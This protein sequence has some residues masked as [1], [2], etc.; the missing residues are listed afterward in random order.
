MICS[1]NESVIKNRKFIIWRKNEEIEWKSI[2]FYY[3][4]QNEM[5]EVNQHIL[6]LCATAL[7]QNA[8][9]PMFLWPLATEH[10]AHLKN[11]SSQWRFRWKTLIK[12]LTDKRS[13]LSYLQIWNFK[14]IYY[15]LK[16]KHVK[17]EKYKTHEKIDYLV[18]YE[19][20]II[21]TVKIWLSDFK[22]IIIE[23][24]IEIIELK[25]D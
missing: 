13:D 9:L 14:V 5:S 1:N 19:N 17:S 18:E 6:H 4:E 10:V 15:I 12:M 20:H 25:S 2:V 16:Q 7:L 11:W 3:S 24:N 23:Q 22:K 21:K 8:R